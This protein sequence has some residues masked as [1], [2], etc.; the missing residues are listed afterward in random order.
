MSFLRKILKVFTPLL[1]R[2]GQGGGSA[3]LLDFFFP[4]T[5]VVCDRRLAPTE[6]SVCAGCL[7][8]LPRILYKGGDEHGR[9][10]KLFWAKVPIERATC[11]LRYD[12]EEVRRIVHTFKY[13]QQPYVAR[14]VAEVIAEELMTTDFFEG[15]DALVPMPLHRRRLHKRGY[16]QCDYLAKGIH[17]VTGIPVVKGTLKRIIDNPS[18]TH[19]QLHE[20]EQNVAN[21]FRVAH[22]E[23]LENK[24]A[25]LIDDVMTTGSTLLSCMSAMQ[26]IS[27]L[28]L[29][30]CVCRHVET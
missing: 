17:R 27:N 11:A 3:A 29:H 15:I 19:L 22:P 10:E 1:T 26:G 8:S 23:L 20:R 6:H 21:V 28:R 13:Y 14:D 18:Q 9:I 12:A 4:R 7:S 5:C 2:E 30:L 24:H 25:L 16:N